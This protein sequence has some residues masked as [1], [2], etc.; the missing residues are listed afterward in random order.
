[1]L[2]GYSFHIRGFG[3]IPYI[4]FSTLMLVE[5]IKL[6]KNDPKALSSESL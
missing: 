3:S 1:M 6:F 2:R 5:V 4:L